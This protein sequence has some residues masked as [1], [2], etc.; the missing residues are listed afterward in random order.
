MITIPVSI[1]ISGGQAPYIFTF[2]SSDSNVTFSNV[3]GTAAY[4]AGI[5]SATTDVLYSTQSLIDTTTISVTF[6]DANGC[7]K[8]IPVTISNPCTLQSSITNNGEFVFV[9]NTTGGSGGYSYQWSYDTSLWIKAVGDNDEDDNYLSLILKDYPTIPSS[10]L[11]AV[12]ITDSNGCSLYKTYN[13]TFC[14]P[15]IATSIRLALVCDSK[16][17]TGC[18]S[19]VSQYRNL[20][21]KQQVIPCSNQVINWTTVKFNVPL[22]LC[23][24]HLGN[25]IITITSNLTT[26]QTKNITYTV[27]TISGI[28]SATGIITVSIPAC[29]GKNPFNGVSQT[30]QLTIED[31]VGDEKF[32]NVESRVAGSPDWSTFTFTNTPNWGTVTFNGNRDIVYEIDDVTTTPSIPDTITWSLNDYSGGQINITDTILRNRIALPTTVTEVVCNACGQ[33]SDPIDLTA[34]DTGDIDKSTVTIVLNDPDIV[35]TKDSNNDFIFTSLPGASFNNLNSY[36]VANTQGAYSAPQNFFVRT[37]CVGTNPNPTLDLTCLVSKAT[38]IKD[39]FT[40]SNSFGDVFTETTA[41]TPTYTTQGGTI[42]GTGD[43]D[44]TSIAT[45]RTYTFEYTAQNQGSCSPDWDDIGIL[46]VIHG[47]TPFI[48]FGTAVDNGNGTSTYP[49]TYSGITTPFSVTLNGVGAT[50]QSGISANNGSG[51]FTLYNTSGTNTVV[52]SATSI[53]GVALSDTD[54][55][56]VI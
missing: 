15:S 24:K 23:V 13:Y 44:F 26:P 42:G 17:V 1:D 7:S 45:G 39:Q 11:I 55:T 47:V 33:T 56:I 12:T 35:I 29:S 43:L 37:A 9:A 27:R 14:Q 41:E 19:V 40:N 38:N 32:L 20:D 46:T 5:Y 6:V 48:N 30:V 3:T 10:T 51:T 4:S 2:T 54:A 18:S 49:F 53:C 34:N 36:K 52:I 8:T 21:L 22:G 25:G 31:I 16:P 50:F 28:I